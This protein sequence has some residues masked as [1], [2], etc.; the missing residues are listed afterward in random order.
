MTING[1]LN[2]DNARLKSKIVIDCGSLKVQ[3]DSVQLVVVEVSSDERRNLLAAVWLLNF[4]RKNS[5][6]IVITFQ[7]TLFVA[8]KLFSWYVFFSGFSIKVKVQS[9]YTLHEWKHKS[10]ASLWVSKGVE[11]A[12]LQLQRLQFNWFIRLYVVTFFGIVGVYNET[13][14]VYLYEI[15]VVDFRFGCQSRSLYDDDDEWLD[16][17]ILDIRAVRTFF[18]LQGDLHAHSVDISLEIIYGWKWKKKL[19]NDYQ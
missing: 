19:W 16:N 13:T 12:L 8:N 1:D 9:L 6:A 2:I 18:A 3:W 5:L 14:I 4:A 15:N 7:L 17:L 10:A 11:C